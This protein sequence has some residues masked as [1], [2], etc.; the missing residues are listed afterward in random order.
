M[1]DVEIWDPETG[2]SATCDF[3][4]WLPGGILVADYK[5]WDGR[6]R[7]DVK[8]ALWSLKGRDGQR[9][10][11]NNPL[12]ALSRTVRGLRQSLDADEI[13]GIVML[14]PQARLG[15]K[16]PDGLVRPGELRAQTRKLRK[17]DPRDGLTDHWQ[18]L[19]SISRARPGPIRGTPG[20]SGRSPRRHL[21]LGWGFLGLAVLFSGTLLQWGFNP[22]WFGG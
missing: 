9:Y 3:V 22:P 4:A 7:G 2:F 11:V 1:T 15:H 6:I 14:G 8:D 18:R 10:R 21:R 17:A 16:P 12:Q 20:V 5:D 13:Y 19:Q